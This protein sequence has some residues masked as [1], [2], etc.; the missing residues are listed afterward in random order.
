MA[1]HTYS[2]VISY[3]CGGQFAQN[4]LHYQF[5]D[6]GFTNTSDA[7]F[8]LANA[9]DTNERT[10]LRNILSQHVQ[11]LSYKARALNVSGGF[12]GILLVAGTVVG[13]RA[14]N[15]STS[16]PSACVILFPNA[17]AKQRGRCFLPGVSDNDAVNGAFTANYKTTF[18]T[19]KHL[20]TDT[21]TLSGGGAPVAT[22]VVYSRLPGPP[23]SRVVEYARLSPMVAT[24]RRRQRPA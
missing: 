11:L 20:F 7:A 15:L 16:A 10:A 19:N 21:L 1:T 13:V 18:D 4:I 9:F 22:P 12:E 23:V 17:N 24:Q 8:A 5:D 3:N 2:L 6:A 14:G